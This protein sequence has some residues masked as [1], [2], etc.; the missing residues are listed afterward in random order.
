MA[1]KQPSFILCVV[2]A[3]AI[4]L[5][6]VIH[7]TKTFFSLIFCGWCCN[8]GHFFYEKP[9][10]FKPSCL[11]GWN[12]KYIELKRVRMHYV[13]YGDSSKP[14]LLF[15]HGFPEFFYCWRNQIKYFGQKDYHVVAVDL[16]GLPL[17]DE[18]ILNVCFKVMEKL[19]DRMAM[20][21]MIWRK[22]LEI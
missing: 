1:G 10:K 20:I 7:V 19:Q 15:V 14:L 16:R 17:D 9:R 8:I 22:L 18:C 5:I 6:C 3:V 4:S 21:T 13:E 2:R 12:D 11:Q